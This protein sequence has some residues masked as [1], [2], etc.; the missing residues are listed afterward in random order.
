MPLPSSGPLSLTD[1]QTE[2]GGS[3]P[4]GLNE[5]YAGGGLVPAGTT[6]T[7]GAVP[8]S[9][10]IAI[11]NFYGTAAVYNLNNSLRFRASASAY[12]SR[13]PASASNRKTWTWSGWVKRGT[14]GVSQ[15][16]FSG[17]TG[18][19]D[20]TQFGI[21]FLADNKLN[22]LGGS[23]T[24]YRTTTQVF[25][26]P[27]AWY[28]IVLAFDT[29]LATANDRIKIYVNGTQIT[30]FDNLTNPTQNVDYGVNQAEAH[31]I[32]RWT[33]ASGYFDG[34]L[35]E[36][37][38][39]DGQ[40]L[41]PSS[42]GET[43]TATGV[44]I[45][46]SYAGSY[47]TNGF[48]LNFS[49]IATTSGSNAG[50]GKDFSGNANYWTTNNI[51]VSSGATYDAMTDVP[52]NTSAT[53]AN[54]CTL[55]AVLQT[56]G[57]TLNDG[58]LN[59]ARTGATGGANDRSQFGTIGVT[60]GKWY[61]EFTAGT[62]NANS[63][64]AFGIAIGSASTQSWAG[65]Q[66]GVVIYNSDGTKTI[67]GTTSSYGAAFATGD[68]IGVAFDADA[69]TLTFYKNNTS[70]GQAA[71]G[72]TSG[73]YFPAVTRSVGGGGS[74]GTEIAN[75]G[76]RPFAYTP[77]S[78]FVALNTFNLPT[79]TIGVTASTQANDY[80]NIALYTGTG[81]SQS[82]TGLGFQPDF[83]WIKERNGSADH[84]LY[85]AVRGVQNQLESNTTTAETTET[86]GLT[87][88]GSDGFTVGALA[89]LNTNNDTYVAWN[90]KANGAGSSN[91]NGTITSTVSANTTAGF[92]VV[93]YTGN[94]SGGATVGHGL[95]VVPKM[96]IVKRRD[97]GAGGTN[98]LVYN[99]NLNNGVNPAQYNLKLN[100]TDATAG[101]SAIWNDTAPTSTVFSLGTNSETNGNGGTFVAYCFA[102]VAGYSKF[103]SYT[104]NGSTDGPFIY[105]GFRPRYI[106]WKET[107]STSPWAIV[108][109]SRSP[110]NITQLGLEANSTSADFSAASSGSW[111]WMDLIS[112]GFKIRS[113]DNDQNTNGGT[114][115]YMAVAE[116]PF[117]YAN[118][119]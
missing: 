105:T 97:N 75:F 45:P 40:A 33:G 3:N 85:D 1:I 80:F 61:W 50:L 42:F 26:D 22:W 118:A 101:L 100:L 10:Q 48:Y 55:N 77:P 38:F 16:F 36:V 53:V 13:T 63:I 65:N 82:I 5:Y 115:I 86:T 15:Y 8:S 102:E 17:G 46:K 28:H 31:N 87:A 84:G 41:T 59:W 79:P 56:G 18:G 64:P 49:D 25:R 9:G 98:W 70:Q 93:T 7:N 95:G 57:Y 24:Q 11:S 119:R 54:Y 106:M 89:Q 104:G 117:K 111:P 99:A 32:G 27:S 94:G 47:G 72:L 4:I 112:N 66:T 35:T 34:Y 92:S 103:G 67:S 107:S 60:S 29:T 81:S 62:V 30:A 90:W 58:N 113:T 6:G 14:L 37:Y 43:S 44:W 114:Y 109:T 69:G 23:G 78:G 83:T 21:N 39:V 51:S 71:S 76:Q 110:S 116:S 88:F 73:P 96:I 91:T 108:D 74:N 2:F 12:L 52:T 19:S 20:T 68:I